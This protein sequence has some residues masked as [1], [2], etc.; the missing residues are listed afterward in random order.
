MALSL[1]FSG[2]VVY[3]TIGVTESSGSADGADYVRIE[4]PTGVI[5]IHPATATSRTIYIVGSNAALLIQSGTVLSGSNYTTTYAGGTVAQTGTGGVGHWDDLVYTA[6][7]TAFV[8][9]VK[10]GAQP[11]PLPGTALVIGVTIT[12]GSAAGTSSGTGLQLAEP[13]QISFG[14]FTATVTTV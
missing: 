2:S 7:T 14:R 13:E 4:G 1:N 11:F 5:E 9:H 10:P 12:P 6:G 3:R 8:A